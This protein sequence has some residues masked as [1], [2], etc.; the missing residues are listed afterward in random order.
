VESDHQ[1]QHAV[2]AEQQEA[3]Q[4][5]STAARQETDVKA[6][7]CQDQARLAHE[8][9]QVRLCCRSAQTPVT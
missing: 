8:L 9:Q 3:L 5:A 4:A 1:Q 6:N 2:D 7:A